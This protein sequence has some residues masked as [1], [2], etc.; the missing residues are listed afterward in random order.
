[1][2]QSLFVKLSS[3]LRNKTHGDSYDISFVEKSTYR[4]VAN[5]K[6][7]KKDLMHTY[8]SLIFHVH[9]GIS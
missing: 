9:V 8:T 6:R 7:G 2:L 1:M 5:K 4:S 3:I